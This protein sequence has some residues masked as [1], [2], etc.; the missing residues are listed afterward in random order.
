MKKKLMLVTLMLVAVFTLIACGEE[1]P[2]DENPLTA[3]TFSG[4]DNVTLDFEEEF[5]VLDGVTATGNNDVDYS[6]L[7][8]FSSTSEITDEGVLD[9]TATG[10]HVVKYEVEV[11]GILAQKFR[12][13]TVRE[14]QAVEGEMLLNPDFSQ[15]TA[16]WDNPS[17][18]Y[19]ADGAAMTLS[20]E[21]VDGN[22]ALKAEVVAGTNSYTPRFGQMN[23]PFEQGV[24][25]E[26]SFKAKSSVEKVINLQVGELLDG[27]P[28]FTDFKEGLT[29]HKTITTEWATYSYK[30]TMTLDNPRGGL[31][32]ELGAIGGVG[33]DATLWFDDITIEESTPDA[34]ETAPAF[35]GLVASR[36]TLIGST[37]DPLAGVTA[38]DIVD[39]DVTEDIVVVIENGLGDVVTTVDT[40]V[41]DT[42]TIT[43]TVSD[44]AGNEAEFVV[45]LE[46]VGMQFNESNL[47]VN[48]DFDLDLG[49]PA[50]WV[51]HD[52]GGAFVTASGI[53]TTAGTYSITTA[54]TPGNPWD[55]KLMQSDI[56][57]VEGN[58]YRVV[59]VMK[60]SA[61][62]TV[63]VAL[64]IPLASEPWW[65]EYAR[66]NGVE[67]TTDFETY[68]FLFTST[69]E[70][71]SDIQIVVEIG[72]TGGYVD[73][74]VEFDS[75]AINEA[76][77]DDIVTNGTFADGWSLWYQNWG[78]MPNV[79]Y[80]RTGGTF[81]ITTDK[82][83][84]ANWAIQ[85]NQV[86]T[87]EPSKTYVFSVDAMASVARD[88]NIKI[89]RADYVNYLEQL[90]QM[91]TTEMV[92]YTFEFTTPAEGQMADLTLSFEMGATANFAAGTVSL[93]NISLKEKDVA[94]APEIIVNGD[95]TTVVGFVYDN[96]GEGAGSMMLGADGGAV[97]E[98]TTLGS[99]PY[100][101]HFYQ[102]IEKL[103]PGDYVLKLVL[104]ASVAR[105][106]R[107]NLVLP[108]AGYAS[109]LPDGSVDFSVVTT[110]TNVVYVNFTVTNEV[111]NVKLELDFGTLPDLVSE[112]GTFTI[113][114]VLIYQDLN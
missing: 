100:T 7:I 80:D 43:Y 1:D 71:S 64:G 90:D 51:V 61:A 34:D 112:V 26:V 78:D 76:I 94:E 54:G 108:D 14:P 5:N 93:D 47:V 17:V 66:F 82:A 8:T 92:T 44:A 23:V 63:N 83:G 35:T 21:E 57:L 70:T 59:L 67:I 46:V 13:I 29:I 4:A 30:F 27:P 62:R 85:F 3:I 111:T 68:E 49:D 16:G 6:D 87:L 53:D 37:V 41:E 18:V 40:S 72:N 88:I 95:A 15:G 32:F 19:I 84:E 39:G 113:F 97:I 25:Y 2:I 11:E 10:N 110:E 81:N 98:V 45:T 105:D 20:T 79:T 42:F 28:Y 75:V 107:I 73:G 36:T 52:E 38:F 31:L 89:F 101:P 74:T 24:T 86:L 104:D 99:Q 69:K 96:A 58:T 109:I 65:I 77:L 106:L 91:L 56:T 102:M 33:V 9:T 103:A 114:E 22:P 50:E 12:T 48:G 60:A 55:I